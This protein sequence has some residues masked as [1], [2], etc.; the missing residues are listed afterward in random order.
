[1]TSKA[2]IV[3]AA[4]SFS[5]AGFVGIVTRE[6]YVHDAMVPTTGDVPTLGF[7]ST[8]YEDGSRVRM[9]D[10][11]KPVRA[12]VLAANHI[13]KEEALFRASL[14]GVE[15]HQV[16]YDLYVD[17]VYQYGSG[18]WLKSSMRRE[19]LAGYYFTACRA[20]L[21]YRKAAG[22]DCSTPGNKRCHGVWDR[23]LDRF[24]T[25]VGAMT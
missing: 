22:F 8:S 24:A 16:E 18:A 13:G 5:A 17:W 9:G 11:I 19:L 1:M 12:V 6:Y 7:G 23:Q 2:R 25:C 10:T 14:P 21:R 3:I 20:L 4:L 15:L